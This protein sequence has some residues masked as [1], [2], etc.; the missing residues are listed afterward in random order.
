MSAEGLRE[1][2]VYS[3]LSTQSSALFLV[4]MSDNL[5]QQILSYLETHNTMTLA[6]SA[7][8]PTRPSGISL[9]VF[10]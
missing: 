8:S 4:A 7:A 9:A 3:L 2:R 10:A 1:E 6:T 5:K